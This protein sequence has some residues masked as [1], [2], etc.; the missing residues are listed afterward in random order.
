[1]T[2]LDNTFKP[3]V[4]A[5]YEPI[6]NQL[7]NI[8]YFIKDTDGTKTMIQSRMSKQIA[9]DKKIKLIGKRLKAL[10]DELNL[11]AISNQ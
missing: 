7:N 1:V 4:D 6:E 9:T 5:R 8:K 2:R 3:L 10:A 11:A